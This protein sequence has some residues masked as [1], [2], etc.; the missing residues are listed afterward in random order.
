VAWDIVWI[1]EAASDAEQCKDVSQ[2]SGRSFIPKVIVIIIVIHQYH[3]YSYY[4]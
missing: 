4:Y 3:Y 1:A 2:I